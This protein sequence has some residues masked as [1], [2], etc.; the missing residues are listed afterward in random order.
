VSAAVVRSITDR[1]WF[2]RCDKR[3]TRL[4]LIS[5]AAAAALLLPWSTAAASVRQV[6]RVLIFNTYGPLSSPGVNL[7]D[8]AIV[9]SL[10]QSPYQ[11]ELYSEN[12]ETTLFPDEEIQRQFLDWSILKY[13]DRKPDVIIAVGREPLKLLAASHQDSFP[14]VPIVFCG[15][16]EEMLDELKLDP[17]F[18]GVWG[19]AQPEKTLIAALRL[20]PS[21]KHVVVTGGVGAY[22]R[23]LESIAKKSF[24]SY[25]SKLDFTWLTELDMPT[26]LERLKHLPKDTI[27]YH[28]SLMQDAAGA[29]FIDAS[30][31]VPL[32]AGAANAPVFVVDDVD[33]RQGTV[34]G[35]LLSF[36]AE[37]RTAA[38]MAVRILNGEKP[39]RI[40]IE[41][42]ANTY[43]F[44][45]WVLDRWGLKERDLPPDSV[46]LNRRPTLWESYKRYIIGGIVLILAETLLIL[47]LLWQRA[48]RRRIEN[49]L[50]RTSDRLRMAVESARS[51]GWDSDLKSGKNRWFGDLHSVFG[52]AGDNHNGQ[53][54]D[55]RK[56]IHPDDLKRVEAAVAEAL[57]TKEPYS[58]ECRIVRTD[59][60]IRWIA[61]R[62][63]YYFSADGEPERML[64]IAT[65][66]TELKLA[67][68][69]LNNL[70]GRLI[71]AQ[72]DERRR[73][74]RELHD[75]FQQRIAVVAIDLENL[76]DEIA[77]DG[78]ANEKLRELWN[79]VGELGSDLHTL[80]HRLHSTTLDTLGLAA[81]LRAL[82][83]E[84]TARH[85]I[86]VVF[87]E[88]DV[89]RKIPPEAALCLFRI[90][91]EALQNVRKHS[92][93]KT[94][95]VRLERMGDN[96]HLSVSDPGVGFDSANGARRDGIGIRSMEERLRLVKGSLAI[97]SR[98]LEGT[99]IEASVP[100]HVAEPNRV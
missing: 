31:S 37:G 7:I 42:S 49:E 45:W 11:I 32:V 41:K 17:S 80:S 16:T 93:A 18:T 75:D 14:D 55:F 25:Q 27:V 74:A 9:A 47:G 79:S 29:R 30:Q 28:T 43:I 1:K 8:Q 44:D 10:Q 50:A 35:D 76:A 19:V 33:L 23:E 67:E 51:A 72:E 100:F 60:Q 63:R 5:L 90:A 84:F 22:D 56:R 65:D 40:P 53:V 4:F 66:I 38:A 12:L 68:E 58:A 2:T 21:T 69:A 54:G 48:R 39:A 52:I 59:G 15:S 26:L 78:A 62:G 57:Q 86:D 98:P 46:L 82:C 36:A 71:Q 95:E 20:Q 89:P 64:G 91:Q 96:V 88:Q 6:R 81:A 24:A 83:E 3:A 94:A 34:G 87:V 73:I 77:W 97:H 13:R 61:A 92:R 85:E 70:S 99:R